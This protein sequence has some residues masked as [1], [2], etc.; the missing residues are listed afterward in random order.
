MSII[1]GLQGASGRTGNLVIKCLKDFPDFKL[2]SAIVAPNC[3]TLGTVCLAAAENHG[4]EIQFTSNAEQGVKDSQVFIDFSTPESAL[5]L[6]SLCARKHIPLLIATTGF[7]AEQ[8]N[9]LRNFPKDCAI[10]LSAN[11][12]LGVFALQELSLLAQ[13]I[14]GS[15]YEVEL[16]ELHHKH[17]KDAPSGTA[18]RT[19]ALLEKAGDLHG[20]L[21]TSEERQ[22]NE[23][24]YASL[25]G[26]DVAGEHTVY[27]L[28]QGE[29][30]ELTHRA[31]D[32]SIF[33]RGALQAARILVKKAPGFYSMKDIYGGSG[34]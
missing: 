12:S 15:T 26:G 22:A 13:K 6:A 29:R 34:E 25:R 19:G 3:P 5:K 21:R 23:L 24:G 16:F 30:I 20:L 31:N 33:A 7:N 1:I 11:F 17:K 4:Q 10:L 28:G 32:R 18:L 27:F 8:E 14:L 2:G 9:M